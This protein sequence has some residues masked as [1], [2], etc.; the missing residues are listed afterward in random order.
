MNLIDWAEKEIELACAAEDESDYGRAC[1]ESALKALKSLCEDGH[2]G[3]S[4]QMTKFILNRLIDG[5]PL[6]PVEDSADIWNEVCWGGPDK[7]IYQCLRMSSLF[8]EINRDGK[9]KFHDNDR[10]VCVDIDDPSATYHNGFVRDIIEEMYPITMPYMPSDKPF[11]VYCE[12]FL[13]DP[14]NGDYDTK[15]IIYVKKPDGERVDVMRYFKENEAS[16]D[17]AFVEIS[18]SEYIDR[19][20]RHRDRIKKQKKALEGDVICRPLKEKK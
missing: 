4:I 10:V 14:K 16:S 6:T 19:K 18:E 13:T 8:K 2:S 1:Y 20:M 15:G 11:M 9:I 3:F 12:T 17:P 5:K 7:T